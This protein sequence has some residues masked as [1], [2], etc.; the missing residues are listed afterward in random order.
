MYIPVGIYTRGAVSNYQAPRIAR[1]TAPLCVVGCWCCCAFLIQF[2]ICFS[3]FFLNVPSPFL[4]TSPTS[5][6]PFGFLTNRIYIRRG[7]KRS[8]SPR[9]ADLLG[10]RRTTVSRYLIP[11]RFFF[12]FFY[13]Y[14]PSWFFVFLKIHFEYVERSGGKGCF[15]EFH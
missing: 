1:R 11:R 7:E 4:Y 14:F 5:Q 2:Y 9:T 13:Y 15:R 12:F 6:P 10:R 8:G 3:V